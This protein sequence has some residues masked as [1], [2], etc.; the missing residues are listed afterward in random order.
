MGKKVSKKTR[1]KLLHI[2][3]LVSVLLVTTV[4]A[5]VAVWSTEVKNL[6][7]KKYEETVKSVAEEFGLEEYL[8]YAMIRTESNFRPEAV[9]S[10]G[11]MGL[12]QL[13][14]ATAQDMADRLKLTD[15]HMG[16][17]TQPDVNIRLGCCYYNWLL[18]RFEVTETAIAA[19]NAG[20][21]EVRK[22]LAD[23]RYSDDGS[24]L[25]EIPYAET[26]QY[27]RKVMSA[28][29]MYHK[30]YSRRS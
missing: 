15:Y 18:K 13:M 27:V 7:P 5:V 28:Y 8:V 30:I 11:A 17:L 6:Y 10:S 3:I 29:E 9:S 25:K 19:Y 16:Q 4:A 14:P 26:R 2:I 20:Q 21:T 1:K 23:P 22:W 12:M 24:T